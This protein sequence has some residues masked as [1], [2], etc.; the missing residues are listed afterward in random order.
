MADTLT[1]EYTVRDQAGQTKTGTMSGNNAKAV[2]DR[3]RESGYAPLSVTEQKESL[4]QK[5]LSIP[6]FGGKVGLKDLAIFARQFATMI[7]SGLS[8]IRALNILAEQT[9]NPKLAE[10]IGEVRSEVEQGRPLSSAMAQHDAVS[11]A[12]HRHGQGR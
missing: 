12:V 4:G 1:F 10:I 2:S 8:L 7:N 6:G 11:Q 9:E 5:E 3:L